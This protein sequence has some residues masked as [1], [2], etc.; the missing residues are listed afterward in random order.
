M[1]KLCKYSFR[2]SLTFALCFFVW[3]SNLFSAQSLILILLKMLQN[4]GL[5]SCGLVLRHLRQ[6]SVVALLSRLCSLPLSLSSAKMKIQM[7]MVQMLFTRSILRHKCGGR[8]EKTRKSNTKNYKIQTTIAGG[9][10]T[11]TRS[12][13]VCILRHLY[14]ETSVFWDV[15]ILIM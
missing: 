10:W 7:W 8:E 9:E 2:N 5:T 14:S 4:N 15:C 12:M 11:G 3:K 6:N 13:T 1:S